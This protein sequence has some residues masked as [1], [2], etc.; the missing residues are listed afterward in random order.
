MPENGHL[1]YHYTAKN[2]LDSV[3]NRCAWRAQKDEAIPPSPEWRGCRVAAGEVAPPAPTGKGA[4]GMGPE[5]VG[6]G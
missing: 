2:A 5:K 3:Q 1:V 6:Y 4:G